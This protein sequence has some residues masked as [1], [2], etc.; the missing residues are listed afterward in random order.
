MYDD[1]GHRVDLDFGDV[2]RKCRFWGVALSHTLNL[3]G[4][5]KV[6]HITWMV[7]KKTKGTLPAL[8]LGVGHIRLRFPSVG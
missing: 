6:I 4:K 3:K 1:M 5:Q 2:L 8:L 7:R